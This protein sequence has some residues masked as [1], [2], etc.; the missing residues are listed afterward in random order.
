MRGFLTEVAAE[1]ATL[2]RELVIVYQ[3]NDRLKGA[4]RDWQSLH[5]RPPGTRA[6]T[7]TAHRAWPA[8]PTATSRR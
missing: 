5:S 7:P 6:T 1:L 3:E 8:N 4:L 2:Q